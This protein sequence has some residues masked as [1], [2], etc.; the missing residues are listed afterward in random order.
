LSFL[1]KKGGRDVVCDYMF[2]VVSPQGE[3]KKRRRPVAGREGT[4]CRCFALLFN[5][6]AEKRKKSK[7][8]RWAL[9]LS[10]EEEK[11]RKEELLFFSLTGGGKKG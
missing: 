9:S 7:S 11:G 2:I 6:P 10:L 8:G 4:G 5:S 1:G 3:G